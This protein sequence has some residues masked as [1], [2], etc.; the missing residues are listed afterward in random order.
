MQEQNGYRQ[1]QLNK[2]VQLLSDKNIL[3][4]LDREIGNGFADYRRAWDAS[5]N[6][7]TVPDFPLTLELETNN[8]C[9]LRCRMCVFAAKDVHPDKRQ[10]AA[11]SYMAWDIFQAM[12]DEGVEHG[13]PAL[14]Y[15]FMS[16]PLL[17]PRIVEMVDYATRRG[18]LDQRLGTNGMLLTPEVSQGL[19]DARLARLE[20]S[21]DAV[22]PDTYARIRHGGSFQRLM[23]NIHAFLELRQRAGSVL[24]LLRVSFL[25]LN[26]NQPE[27]D[28]FMAYWRKYADYFSVQEPVDYELELE[29]SDLEFTSSS[30]KPEY[31]CDKAF[32]RLFIRHDGSVLACGHIHAWKDFLLGKVGEDKLHDLWHSPLMKE[33][34]VIH[35]DGEYHQNPICHYCV[36]HTAVAR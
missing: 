10:G 12:I 21:V 25:R 26:V 34:R 36:T 24:P 20:V 16:E 7:E 32:Q 9:N 31:H 19:I 30:E 22:T 2:Q 35:R 3:E 27:F 1:Q 29:D 6:L 11:K 5:M 33:L 18:V 4:I 14:T 15:G 13:L 17:H 8:F 28:D 23:E